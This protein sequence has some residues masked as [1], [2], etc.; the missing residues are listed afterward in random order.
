MM[1]PK[2]FYISVFKLLQHSKFEQL[3]FHYQVDETFI[4][5]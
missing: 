4:Y 3:N 1:D 5:L 2:D